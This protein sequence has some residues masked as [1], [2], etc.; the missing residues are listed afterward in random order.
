MLSLLFL[1]EPLEGHKRYMSTNMD[2]KHIL[3]CHEWKYKID[4]NIHNFSPIFEKMKNI[5]QRI[6]PPFWDKFPNNAVFFLEPPHNWIFL[7]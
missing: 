3:Y 1:I 4:Q 7:I 5:F 6:P 2:F